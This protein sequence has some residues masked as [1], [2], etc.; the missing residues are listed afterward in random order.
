ME[1]V[2]VDLVKFDLGKVVLID[3]GS[4]KGNIVCVV[5]VVFGGMLWYLVL[6]YLI[7]GFEQSGVIVVKVILFCWYKVIFMFFV[8]IDVD[9]LVL[10][11][12]LWC[13]LGVD[14]EYMEVEYYD[15][16]LVVISYLF[17][18]LVFILVDF[19]VKCSEN[20]EIFCY[21]VGGFCDFIWIVGSD[22]VMWYD[23]FFVNCEVVLCILDVFC[24]DFDVL[25][26][27]VDIGDGYQLLGV[28]MCVWVVCEYFSKILVCWVYVD[29]MYNNDL[30]YLVQLGG[31]LFGIIWVL[32][33]KLIFY[34]LI[35]FGFL[36]EG[37][38]EV[39]G[40][41]EGEDVLVIIQV[42]CDMGVVI[43]G[44]QNGCVIVYGVGLYGFKVLFG[45]IYLGNFG[46]FMCLFSGLLVVQLF[47]SIL[48]G[49][50][51][52][53]KWLMNCVVKLLCE[54]GV[55]IEMGLEGC[56]LMIICGGQC[57]IGMYYDMLMVSVQVKFCLLFVG[58][59]V[60]GEILVIELVLICDY[61]EC[62]LCG[63]GY[64]VVVEGSIV[65]VEFGYKLSVIYIEVLVDIF[66]VVFF[67]V[68][69]SIVEGLELV[70]Q[71]VGINLMCVGVIEILCLMGGDL[72]LENQCEV[73]G[74]LVVDI[75][76]C[77]VWF[78]GIDIFEDL[79]LLVIDE[80]L[81][82]F[83]VV[84]CVEGCMVLCG[85]EEL[86]VKELDCIQVM[87]DGLKVLG[88]KVELILDGIVIEGG[89]F[90]GGEVW[91]YGD[92]CIVMFFSVVLLCVSGLICIYDCVNVVIFF[93][94]FFVLCVQIGIWVVVEN[95]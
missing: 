57:F 82:F 33:D 65:K 34:C 55:V 16:V 46:I 84:V 67:L 11:D 92:Y 68:V 93:F 20:L 56:L 24:D 23:I 1:W 54:M 87:V 4:V 30:I 21:V 50:V 14:V 25:C 15:E 69:V 52:F 5:C 51:F 36:V 27:V 60:V 63:F 62:M 72:S 10:V 49:D 70:L 6:G 45:L 13:V 29:V 19:L 85:V 28:F 76:V 18:L 90:G 53:F 9:V 37:I 83:V 2:L 38:I 7:V 71:Y 40:F 8:E 3:V 75:C 64:L 43:E 80:F 88:V 89:V 81:V 22:L 77:F 32:G 58:F 48:I 42:F 95:N 41:F 91:V 39:E 78:K 17:Y 86:W 61:I 35:M 44:L 26:E 47:D 59:Y 79:V 94:N 31:S 73:G 66:L 74:E 12:S